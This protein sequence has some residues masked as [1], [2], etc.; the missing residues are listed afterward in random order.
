VTVRGDEQTVYK[1]TIYS[2]DNRISNTTGTIRARAKLDN[3]DGR[4][5]PGM[6]VTVR[7]GSAEEMDVLTV[8][9]RA[10]GYDQNKTFV[11]V[12]GAGNKV[13]YREIT[14]GHEANGRRLVLSGLK[15]GDRVVV[16]GIQHAQPGMTVAPQEES[17]APTSNPPQ[18]V[19]KGG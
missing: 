16:D 14:L 19:S 5:V 13:D 18:S 8:P 6:F 2:F 17:S 1:G 15:P 3:R 4:L 11:L 12:A 7:L 9:D 10:I